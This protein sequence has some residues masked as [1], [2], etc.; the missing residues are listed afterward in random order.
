MRSEGHNRSEENQEQ[1]AVV[2]KQAS[3]WIVEADHDP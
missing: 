1:I 2:F 3:F